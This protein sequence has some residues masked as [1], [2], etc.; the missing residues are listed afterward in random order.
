MV[1]GT[2]R[3]TQT[4][5]ALKPN[6]S[7]MGKQLELVSEAR[8]LG[9]NFDSQLRFEN[10]VVDLA[11]NC[12]YRLKVLYRI[13]S[14]ISIDVRIKL[15]ETLVLSKLNYCLGVYGPCLYK[16]TE[17]IVQRIQN[18]CARF[19]FPIPPRSHVSPF[20]NKSNLLKMQYRLTLMY[21]C[22]LHDIMKYN[23]PKYLS[24]KLSWRYS[25][26]TRFSARSCSIVLT[27]PQHRTAAFRGG[28]SYRASKCWNDIPPPLR[29]IKSKIT[30][31]KALREYLLNIQKST[32]A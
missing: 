2:K 26:S 3:Q 31:K 28:F 6:V 16:K 24:D 13:R 9:L 15:C 19:C 32:A 23:K 4:I 8:N 7:I 29:S 11:R 12:F 17:R 14:F 25:D 30:F 5:V 1:I 20:L 18:A 22:Q 21:A 10:H 27:I